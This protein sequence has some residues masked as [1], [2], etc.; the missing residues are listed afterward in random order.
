[1][2]LI[3]VHCDQKIKAARQKNLY[4]PWKNR[5]NVSTND[6]PGFELWLRHKSKQ[7][8]QDLQEKEIKFVKNPVDSTVFK[9]LCC[10]HFTI[11]SPYIGGTT[12]NRKHKHWHLGDRPI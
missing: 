2:P 3:P 11:L 8:V 12:R 9:A 7:D 4:K 1:M 5:Q 6:A 10:S